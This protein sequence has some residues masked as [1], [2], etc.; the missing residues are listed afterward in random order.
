MEDLLRKSAI[1]TEVKTISNIT[2][3]KN[4]KLFRQSYL[5]EILGYTRVSDT[6]TTA[7]ESTALSHYQPPPISTASSSQ[8]HNQKTKEPHDVTCIE[9]MT[10]YKT[11]V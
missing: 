4:C 6:L 7:T 8:Q 3:A 10:T 11:K 2:D 1:A 9:L 5:D